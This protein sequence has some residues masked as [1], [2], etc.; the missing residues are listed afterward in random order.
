MHGLFVLYVAADSVTGKVCFP[1]SRPSQPMRVRTKSEI[2]RDPVRRRRGSLYLG[3]SIA[4]AASY[5]GLY[6]DYRLRC[7]FPRRR[8]RQPSSSPRSPR[9]RST[10][11]FI[12]FIFLFFPLLPLR[13]CSS[14]F[15]TSSARSC[16]LCVVSVLLRTRET[17]RARVCTLAIVRM[18]TCRRTRG[19]ADS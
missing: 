1:A 18:G 4:R 15:L 17:R 2:R 14:P 8:I 6:P 12:L 7:I 3:F 13:S 16:C 9:P 11:F 10:V 5:T 19:Y